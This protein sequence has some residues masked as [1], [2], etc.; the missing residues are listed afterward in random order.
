[1]YCLHC[2]VCTF[3]THFLISTIILI[4][5]PPTGPVLTQT[6]LQSNPLALIP[7]PVSKLSLFL[8]CCVLLAELTDGRWEIFHDYLCSKQH[9]TRKEVQ[10]TVSPTLPFRL[11]IAYSLSWKEWNPKHIFFKMAA[12]LRGKRKSIATM[13]A[14]VRVFATFPNL[15]HSYLSIS[16]SQKL[17]IL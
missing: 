12:K 15:L 1:M 10:G 3:L 14:E 5:S 17:P 2:L 8:S 11:T 9:K 7:P 13:Q 4:P 16:V 6:L